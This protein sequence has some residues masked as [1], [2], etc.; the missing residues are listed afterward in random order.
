MGVQRYILQFSIDSSGR[1]IWHL[2]AEGGQ[3]SQDILILIIFLGYKSEY[4]LNLFFP[5]Q[6]DDW[7]PR[8]GL[9]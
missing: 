2:A 6:D 3:N 4:K 7:K 9:L 5:A 8:Y 1:A